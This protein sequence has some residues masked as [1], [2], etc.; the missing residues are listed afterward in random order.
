ML[1][2]VDAVV[3]RAIRE[4]REAQADLALIRVRLLHR[5]ADLHAAADRLIAAANANSPTSVD[6]ELDDAITTYVR[7]TSLLAQL[8]LAPRT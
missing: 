1:S 3:G 4:Q 7:T 2:D 6:A 5:A 8:G